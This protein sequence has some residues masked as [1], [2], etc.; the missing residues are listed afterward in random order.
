MLFKKYN[1]YS[2]HYHVL[3][4]KSFTTKN[5]EATKVLE[6]FDTWIFFNPASKVARR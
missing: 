3:C 2:P 6:E 5:A 4:F 1:V